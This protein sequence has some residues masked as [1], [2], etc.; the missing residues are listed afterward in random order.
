MI[1]RWGSLKR[2][3]VALRITEVRCPPSIDRKSR[4]REG[5][6]Y[7]KPSVR[8]LS[9]SRCGGVLA[10]CANQI[11]RDS[12]WKPT[13]SASKSNMADYH[14]ANID[15]RIAMLRFEEPRHDHEIVNRCSFMTM[16]LRC[17]SESGA[18]YSCCLTM[19]SAL[20][21]EFGDE[22]LFFFRRNC[23]HHLCLG[24]RN[25]TDEIEARLPLL[26]SPR[27]AEIG[28]ADTCCRTFDSRG[29]HCHPSTLR[30]LMK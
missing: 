20:R 5:I 16:R 23:E 2:C 25:I 9:G 26:L 15:G 27:G 12:V 1:L 14:Q 17:G 21:G 29:T 30:S 19:R 24:I 3:A 10:D 22:V 28:R 7:G 4:S 8:K 11:L 13:H 6:S 18:R